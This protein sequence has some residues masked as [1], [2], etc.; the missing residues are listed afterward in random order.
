M[1]FNSNLIKNMK[2]KFNWIK[3]LKKISLIE[4]KIWKINFN[5][6]KHL[7]NEV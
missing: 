4:F 7:K 1:K 3:N 5:W 6:I 2:H